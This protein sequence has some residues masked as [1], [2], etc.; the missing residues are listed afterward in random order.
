MVVTASWA[1]AP[2]LDDQT[3]AALES[4][5]HPQLRAARTRGIPHMG[6][7]MIYPV[8]ETDVKI[9]DFEIPGHWKR[10]YAMDAGGGAKPTAACWFTQ[11][12]ESQTL[13]LYSV[14]KRVASEP[15]IHATA[16]K[17][18][19]EWM[20][21]VGDCAALIM[22]DED[23]EQLIKLYKRLGLNLSLPDK[24]V[25]TGIQDV[26]ELLSVGKLRVFA[27]CEAWFEEYRFYRR[28]DKGRIVKKNDHLQDC[29]RYFV[30]SG[31][32]LM[33]LKPSTGKIVPPQPTYQDPESRRQNW[34][35]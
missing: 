16:I 5:I 8:P 11:D 35:R 7:G 17:A 2:H 13:Y 30:R 33:K 9:K 14:Y 34:M 22:T 27:S 4:T 6:A 18:R 24:A 26:W 31:R 25:E 23:A 12:P 29:V 10:G 32:Q 20:H 3:K 15:V 28:D 19:G 21:G 1:Q